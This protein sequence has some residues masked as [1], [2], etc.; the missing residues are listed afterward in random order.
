MSRKKSLRE[1]R[2]EFTEDTDRMLKLTERASIAAIIMSGASV[3][4]R[5]L[6]LLLK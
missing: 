6:H 4:L 2:K 1:K 3:M 5:L